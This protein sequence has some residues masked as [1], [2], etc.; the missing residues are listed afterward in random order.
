MVP[1]EDGGGRRRR[2]LFSAAS[3]AAATRV[4]SSRRRTPRA[5]LAARRQVRLRTDTAPLKSQLRRDSRR[6]SRESGDYRV[7]NLRSR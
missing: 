2:R 3:R 6:R 5:R 1:V 7:Y 4:S